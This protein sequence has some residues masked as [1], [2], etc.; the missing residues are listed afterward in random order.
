MLADGCAYYALLR[1]WDQ[2]Y[3]LP[4]STS[5][6]QGRETVD[7]AFSE[8]E[9]LWEPGVKEAADAYWPGIFMQRCFER[10]VTEFSELTVK[11]PADVLDKVKADIG[12]SEVEGM[13]VSKQDCVNAMLAN[14]VDCKR[15]VYAV[16]I[17]PHSQLVPD[18]ALANAE[19]MWYAKPSESMFRAS[20]VRQSI[21]RRGAG[22]QLSMENIAADGH[23]FTPTFMNSWNRIQHV[24]TFDGSAGL[25]VPFFSWEMY[26]ILQRAPAMFMYRASETEYIQVHLGLSDR[27]VDEYK[28]LW[29]KYGAEVTNTIPGSVVLEHCARLIRLQPKTFS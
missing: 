27:Q 20:D 7:A 12:S 11:V 15:I 29:A 3:G 6:M 22:S 17:R 14:V 2:E 13:V 21:L 16:N 26:F 25:H 8:I 28:A 18:T 23:R 24:P 9:G 10:E 1:A 5:P 4:G 19:M